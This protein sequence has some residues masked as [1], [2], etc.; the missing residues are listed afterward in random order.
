MV[1]IYPSFQLIKALVRHVRK[2]FG[3]MLAKSSF[4][5]LTLLSISHVARAQLASENCAGG[6]YENQ[7]VLDTTQY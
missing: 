6:V 7:G 5:A 4:F 2:T 3:R 1:R